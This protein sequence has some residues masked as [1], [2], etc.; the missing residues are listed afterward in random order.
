MPYP[1][2][3]LNPHEE[4][5]VD[6]HPHWWYYAQPA[7]AIFGAIA[8]GIVTLLFTDSDTTPRTVLGWA[9]LILLVGSILWLIS[10]YTKWATTNFVI[11]SD[12]L[13]YRSG[14]IA[15]TGVEIPLERVNTVHFNQTVFERMVGAGDLVIESGGEDG[16]QRF[17]DIHNPDRVQREIHT[18]MEANEQRRFT[19]PSQPVDVASQLEKLEGM[20]ERGT[21]TQEEFDAQKSKLLGG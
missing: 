16:Q 7:A 13:I 2:K 6:L 14:V 4:V 20:L 15:K 19:I 11:T 21:L 3:L 9:S 18:Q 8:L 17:T 10:R 1:K 12:R 5:A